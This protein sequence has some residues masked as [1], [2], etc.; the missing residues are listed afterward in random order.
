VPVLRA[1]RRVEAVDVE[2]HV[3]VLRELGELEALK[4]TRSEPSS[5]RARHS[6][7]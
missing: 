4:S 1:E 6:R 2:R 7:S 3:D 5:V